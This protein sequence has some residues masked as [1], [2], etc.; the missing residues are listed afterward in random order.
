[1]RSSRRRAT[2]WTLVALGIAIIALGGVLAATFPWQAGWPQTGWPQTAG[3][4]TAG[5]QTAA[6][7]TGAPQASGPQASVPP[8]GYPGPWYGYHR[9]WGFPHGPRFFGGGLLIALIVILVVT[10]A[11]RRG[12][13]WGHDGRDRGLDAEEILRRTFAEGRITEEEYKS[14]LAALRK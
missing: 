4:Q 7:Q 1:M 5:P 10:V 3:P 11:V 6:P 14:R 2:T 12:R 13:Y 8:T 9:G